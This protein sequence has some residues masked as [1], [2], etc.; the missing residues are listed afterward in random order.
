MVD[1]RFARAYSF[2][3]GGFGPRRDLV[4]WMA[5]SNR[6]PMTTPRLFLL[7]FVLLLAGC[8]TEDEAPLFADAPTMGRMEHPEML[9]TIDQ[10]RLDGSC[11][12]NADFE[13]KISLVNFWATWC[14]PC[15]VEIPE[16]VALQEEWKDR[17]F[18]II[19]VSLDEEG[20]DII[21]PFVEDFHMQ[22]PQIVDPRG[23]LGE[24]FGGAYALPVTFIVDGEGKILIG[25]AGLFPL[26]E[27]R[28]DLDRLVKR[29][30]EGT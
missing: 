19:G 9:P 15:V 24:A 23:E 13:G 21:R 1:N 18:Q 17:P 11:L 28:P 25:H 14:G 4:S 6:L 12:T 3:A 10:E 26:K 29:I 8:A 7:T 22:Y 20:F 16:F 2:H 30:E 5:H 27:Y